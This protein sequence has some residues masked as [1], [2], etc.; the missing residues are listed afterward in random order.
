MR[1]EYGRVLRELF[2]KRMS[3]R[4]P[5]FSNVKVSTIYFTPGDRA[6]EKKLDDGT[7]LWINL[8]IDSKL[9]CFNIEIGWSDLGRWPELG[10]RPSPV[11]PENNSEFKERE[12][13]T[14]LPSLWT[15][16]D[17]WFEIEP[18]NPN[19][20]VEDLV[21]KTKPID[22]DKAHNR[23][24]PVVEECIEKISKYGVPYL[25]QRADRNA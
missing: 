19:L 6:F 9:E 3:E 7:S 17:Y 18:F 16:I 11:R 14:R 4:H 2:S 1:K 21:K 5:E 24:E 23:V 20:N 15:E 12:Y 8:H 25:Q 13:I 22:K 10:M